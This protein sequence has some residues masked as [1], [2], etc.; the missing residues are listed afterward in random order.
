MI[1]ELIDILYNLARQHEYVKS[2]N[3]EEVNKVGGVGSDKYPLVFLEDPLIITP[4]GNNSLN[5]VIAHLDVVDCI[6]N[7]D[8][9]QIKFSHAEIQT[10]CMKIVT[11]FI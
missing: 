4:N 3:Y 2:F 6:S 8:N 1:K 10:Y 7:Y 11:D 9:E 5:T